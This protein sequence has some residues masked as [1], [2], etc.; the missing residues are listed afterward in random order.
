MWTQS[1]NGVTLFPRVDPE[2]AKQL[3]P[4]AIAD[5]MRAALRAQRRKACSGDWTYQPS[6]HAAM[7]AT[8][9]AFIAA[10][11]EAIQ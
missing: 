9:R 8:Y 11:P 5:A 3:S 6:H 1:D 7:L 2:H 4:Q 10:H